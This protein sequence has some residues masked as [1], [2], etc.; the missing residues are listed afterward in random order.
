MSV[1]VVGALWHTPLDDVGSLFLSVGI[2]TAGAAILGP[3][4]STPSPPAETEP[5]S[6]PQPEPQPELVTAGV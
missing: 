6:E 3:K 4:K 1:V 2:V 5:G